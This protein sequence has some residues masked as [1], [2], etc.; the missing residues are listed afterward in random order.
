MGHIAEQL[1]ADDLKAVAE[2][3]ASLPAAKEANNE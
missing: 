3:F 1:D 2:Y